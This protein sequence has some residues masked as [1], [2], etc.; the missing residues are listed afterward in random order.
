VSQPPA[1]DRRRAEFP[2]LERGIHLLSHSL[3]PVPRAARAA[4][5]GY[6]E[7]WENQIA[8]DPWAADAWWDLPRRTGDRIARLLG[9]PPGSVQVQPNASVALSVAASCLDFSGPRR[10]VVTGG[11]DFPTTGY[12]WE[13]M[14]PLGAEVVVVPSEDG[15]VLPLERVL[16]AVDERT[17][18]VALSHVSYKS[19]H[20]LDPRPLIEKARRFGAPV[21]LDVYQSAG[22]LEI[23]AAGWGVDFLIGGTIKWLCGGPAC[24]Y[25]YVRPDLAPRLRPRLTGWFAHER[26]FDF[27]PGPIRPAAGAR[28]FAQGTPAIPALCA[29]LPGLELLDAVGIAAVAAESRRRTRRIVER[30][31]ERGWRIRCPRAPEERGGVVVIDVDRPD[32]V[33]RRLRERRVLV[34]WRPGA[35]IRLG[36]HFF[37]TDEEIE[38]ALAALAEAAG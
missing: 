26:P 24:G 38:A 25:L 9:A 30:V 23:D 22:I 32:E 21:L 17:A 18:V 8:A 31:L 28:R 7:V 16:D 29:C 12:V 20:R 27:E 13:A 11:L 14:R 2:A 5:A 1:I 19:S 4:L 34:D 36:P 35:G 33:A 10:R 3:G 15:I 6:L 37:N